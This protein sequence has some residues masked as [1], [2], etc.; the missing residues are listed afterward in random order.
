MDDNDLG[1]RIDRATRDDEEE[2]ADYGAPF[3]V[4]PPD[5]DPG[6]LGDGLVE[7]LSAALEALPPDVR[8]DTW[9][10]LFTGQGETRT[11]ADGTHLAFL[12]NG[13]ILAEVI[14]GP[15]PTVQ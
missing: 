13:V 15:R 2:P 7:L 11:S 14:V 12:V 9:S 4:L 5:P 3:L 1:E 10:A 8:R 6:K